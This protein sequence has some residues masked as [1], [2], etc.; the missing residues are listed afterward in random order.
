MIAGSGAWWA[1]AGEELQ[2]FVEKTSLPLFTVCLARGVVSDDHPLCFG[3]ADPTLSR[4]AAK[5]FK[6]A[7]VVIVLGKKLDYRLRMGGA[8]LFSPAAKF[9]QVD[10]HP[11]ELGLNRR[12][13]VGIQSDVKLALT[14]LLDAWGKRPTPDRSAWLGEVQKASD[15]WQAGV[16]VDRRETVEPDAPAA[17]LLRNARLAPRG[18]DPMLGRRRFRPLGPLQHPHAQA[19]ALA[20]TGRVGPGWARAS[21]SR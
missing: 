12:L 8:Q 9:A 11:E 3:Y 15:A 20:A 10:I 4:G 16:G 7:D 1:D 18:L 19:N 6:D 14:A 13:E 5:A 2:S 21:Q 17:P